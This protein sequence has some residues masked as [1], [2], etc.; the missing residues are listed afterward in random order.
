MEKEFRCKV[1]GYEGDDA[2]DFIKTKDMDG[3]TCNDCISVKKEFNLSEKINKISI[4][5]GH[6]TNLVTEDYLFT[7]QVKEFIKL[8]KEELFKEAIE[9][10]IPLTDPSLDILP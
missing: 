6:N 9:R 2:I 4:P 1:C 5:I 7:S 3:N 8:L 10:D